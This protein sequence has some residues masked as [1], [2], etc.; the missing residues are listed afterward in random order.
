MLGGGILITAPLQVPVDQ[1]ALT[2]V[3]FDGGGGAGADAA[4][5]GRL[6]VLATLSPADLPAAWRALAFATRLGRLHT[7]R[8]EEGGGA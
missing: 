3:L 5:L 1:C 6:V 8:T 7:V 4:A 2:A